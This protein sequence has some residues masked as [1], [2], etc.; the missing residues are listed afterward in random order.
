MM[1]IERGSDVYLY[2]L[3]RDG[4]PQ[5]GLQA[6]PGETTA[7]FGYPFRNLTAV[8]SGVRPEEFCGPE[9][10]ARLQDLDWIGPR[11]CRHEAVVEEVMRHSPVFPLPFG[12]I[13][14]CTDTLHEFLSRRHDRIVSFLGQMADREE[15]AVK[16]VLEEG[17]ARQ[18][19]IDGMLDRALPDRQALPPGRRYF[20]ER[21]LQNQLEKAWQLQLESTA[22]DLACDL[23]RHVCAFC[24]REVPGRG[25][26]PGGAA[27][28]F[29]WALLVTRERGAALRAG[30]EQ[31]EDRYRELGVRLHLSG[32]WPPYSFRPMLD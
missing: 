29:N 18:S 14:S 22:R 11:A 20:E 10:E 28:L 6:G 2:C 23:S 3:A 26:A 30:L 7:P 8:V 12:T 13:F 21:R 25:N 31:N 19:F 9:A 32:P 17:T 16:G 5:P 4:L 15:W 1:H 27:M 24:R